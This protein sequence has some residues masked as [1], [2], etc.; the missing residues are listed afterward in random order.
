MKGE[1]DERGATPAPGRTAV[2]LR[3]WVGRKAGESCL[4]V[5]LTKAENGTKEKKEPRWG[6]NQNNGGPEAAG[7]ALGRSRDTESIITTIHL[8]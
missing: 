8:E 3:A 4:R 7:S 1:S 2:K 5:N 6:Q